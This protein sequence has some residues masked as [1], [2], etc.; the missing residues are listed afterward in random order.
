MESKGFKNQ[1]P[2][3]FTK[4]NLVNK[5]LKCGR[6]INF[7]NWRPCFW[8]WPFVKA[9]NP[10]FSI[11]GVVSFMFLDSVLGKLAFRALRSIKS[12]FH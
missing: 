2:S 4:A 7:P 1:I 11:Y 10:L 12:A 3:D 8:R 6:T 5:C 9:R